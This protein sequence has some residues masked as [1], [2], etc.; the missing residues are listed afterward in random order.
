MWIIGEQSRECMI[1]SKSFSHLSDIVWPLLQLDAFGHADL[2]DDR[3]SCSNIGNNLGKTHKSDLNTLLSRILVDMALG[4]AYNLSLSCCEFPSPISR[5]PRY[6]NFWVFW[7][8]LSFVLY[9]FWCVLL[10]KLC[11]TRDSCNRFVTIHATVSYQWVLF[12]SIFL[13]RVRFITSLDRSPVRAADCTTCRQPA[14]LVLTNRCLRK[15]MSA[16]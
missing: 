16:L 6:E 13:S 1:S 9:S 5:S 3:R 15:H 4:D 11:S 8:T 2:A 10:V 14:C 12:F 7:T